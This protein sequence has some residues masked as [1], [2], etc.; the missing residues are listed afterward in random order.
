MNTNYLIEYGIHWFKCPGLDF[1]MKDLPTVL[2]LIIAD[3]FVNDSL[4]CS[5]KCN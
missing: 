2:I 1:I 3:Q 4:Y 5:N